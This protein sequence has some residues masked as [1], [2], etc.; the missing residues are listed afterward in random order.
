MTDASVDWLLNYC[1]KPYVHPGHGNRTYED[2]LFDI[3]DLDGHVR[4]KL[5]QTF[6]GRLAIEEAHGLGTTHLCISNNPITIDGVARLLKSRQ[7]QVL[8]VGAILGVLAQ[9]HNRGAT[10]KT[11]DIHGIQDLMGMAMMFA[12][13]RLLYLRI[14]HA[15]V[16]KELTSD[17]R[18]RNTPQQPTQPGPD[19]GILGPPNPEYPQYLYPHHLAKLQVIVLTGIPSHT[20]DASIPAG[21]ISCIKWCAS[22]WLLAKQLEK[23]VP[24][25]P[26]EE[27]QYVH[28]APTL[29]RIVLEI[30]PAAPETVLLPNKREEKSESSR[31]GWR[32]QGSSSLSMTEDPDSDVLW[33]AASQDFSFFDG[34]G[35][36]EEECDMP[37]GEADRQVSIETAR[38]EGLMVVD[39]EG[40]GS[41]AW[42][43]LDVVSELAKFRR[44]KREAYNVAV[45]R[46]DADP[47]I[48]GYWPGD[49]TVVRMPLNGETSASDYYRDRYESGWMYQ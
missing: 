3:I 1:I 41:S 44:E 5:T 6:V 46:G 14:N 4:S 39:E 35:N 49:V 9:G 48:E 38:G 15:V 7:L 31:S 40:A 12:T 21:L 22:A 16:T 26:P 37:R 18:Y 24:R 23:A 20:T 42:P 29:R 27:R 10:S 47:E 34:D 28:K 36:G 8:D 25:L 33:K 17:E 11:F 32:H 13:K 45:Q 19:S 43:I 2:D 30:V